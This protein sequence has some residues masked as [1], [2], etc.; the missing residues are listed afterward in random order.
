LKIQA[1]G[2][3]VIF[4]IIGI[5]IMLFGNYM[6]YQTRL[7]LAFGSFFIIGIAM[8]YSAVCIKRFSKKY[9]L[10]TQFGENEYS[11]W[12]GLYNYLKSETLMNERTILELAIWEQYLIYRC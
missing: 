12:R 5:I 6:S 1:I 9:V 7:D 4:A 3:S 10:L 2:L 8:I 11:K